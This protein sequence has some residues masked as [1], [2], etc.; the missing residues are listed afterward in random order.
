MSRFLLGVIS[1]LAGLGV[2]VP[3]W[4]VRGRGVDDGFVERKVRS[5]RDTE[6]LGMGSERSRLMARVEVC[7]ETHEMWRGLE[8]P[9][10]AQLL[11]QW[12]PRGSREELP[13]LS[14]LF[15]PPFLRWPKPV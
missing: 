9:Q 8:S 10:G 6:P 11:S 3:A 15:S 7:S 13:A 1:V 14:A 2:R 4:T 5:L 12:W